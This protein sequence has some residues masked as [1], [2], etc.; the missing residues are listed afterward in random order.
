ML[1]SPTRA[2]YSEPVMASNA[3]RVA[4]LATATLVW[5]ATLNAQNALYAVYQDKLHLVRRVDRHTAYVDDGTGKLVAAR[6]GRYA[7]EHVPEF[8]PLY[9]SVRNVQ[10][11]TSSVELLNSGDEINRSFSFI[12]D[13]ESPYT[14]ENVFV[15]LDL[16]TEN[17]GNGLFLQEIG[18]L[19]P[20]DPKYVAIAVPLSSSL[21][22]G[23]YRLHVFVDGAEV[24]QSL[25]PFDQIERSLDAMVRR[26]IAGA[27]D[28]L[29]KPF[30]GPAPEYP[31]KLKRAK[32]KG[33][34]VIRFSISATGR[35]LQPVIKSA[36]DPA[37]GESALEAARQWRFLP[38]IKNGVPIASSVELPFTFDP[39]ER[40]QKGG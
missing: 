6:E 37:F 26:R 4:L 8:L 33:S 9:V 22:H 28:S 17:A 36:T 21:G 40:P 3:V 23:Q 19:E 30:V 38:R 27:P 39:T 29:P 32:V 24:F 11:R 7:L 15:V 13:F 12:A 5:A 34:A 10:V 16:Q 2:G 31:P 25:I 1:G 35:V 20:R 14:L 18:R